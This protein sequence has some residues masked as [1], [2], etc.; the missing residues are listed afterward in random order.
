MEFS[1]TDDVPTFLKMV[2]DSATRFEEMV[3]ERRASAAAN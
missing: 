3:A 2:R 1:G